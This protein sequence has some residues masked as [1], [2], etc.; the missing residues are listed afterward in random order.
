MTTIL[1]DI[2]D[3]LVKLW[4]SRQELVDG[5]EADRLQRAAQAEHEAEVRETLLPKDREVEADIAS[6]YDQWLSDGLSMFSEVEA[7]HASTRSHFG[8]PRF[9]VPSRV[10]NIVQH[11]TD[12]RRVWTRGPHDIEAAQ[13]ERARELRSLAKEQ[14]KL[15]KSMRGGDGS[16]YAAQFRVQETE[17]AADRLEGK[18]PTVEVQDGEFVSMS[19]ALTGV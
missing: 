9:R 3:R 13:A 6:R 10:R 12:R 19:Q 16:K 15:A 5:A 11:E 17:A 7:C 2:E 8:R 14:A 1:Q 4:E 18:T